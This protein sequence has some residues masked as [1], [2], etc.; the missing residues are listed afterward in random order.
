MRLALLIVTV[1]FVVGCSSSSGVSRVGPDTYTISTSASPGKG[2]VPAAKK[3][4]YQEAE[5]ACDKLGDL[6]VFVLNEKTASPTWSDGMAHMDL[7]FR[8][9]HA[10][11]PEFQ[12]QRLESSPDVIVENRQR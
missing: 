4:A 1:S 9:L 2:G 11:D 8:C 3:I 5:R 12:R 10:D 6:E 7:D